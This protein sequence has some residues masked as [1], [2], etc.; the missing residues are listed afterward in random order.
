LVTWVIFDGHCKS[1]SPSSCSF[2]VSRTSYVW[3]K[4]RPQHPILEH[5][6]PIFLTLVWNPQVPHPHET[7][8][9]I[10]FL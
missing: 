7:I 3:H 1:R 2:L 9:K 8:L 6:L 10:M 5:L 4:Y